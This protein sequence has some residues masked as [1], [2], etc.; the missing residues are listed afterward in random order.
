[1]KTQHTPGPWYHF[2]N[3]VRHKDND[4]RYY[5]LICQCGHHPDKK[6]EAKA[7]AE[8]IASAPTMA[9]KLDAIAARINGEWDNIALLK[10]LG[11]LN[12]SP[13]EDIQKILNS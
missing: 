10:L 11:P 9:E 6:T 3:E 12:T 1:M 4:P 13:I 7:N 8:L 5:D 2:G